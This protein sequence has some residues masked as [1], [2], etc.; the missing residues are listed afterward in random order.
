MGAERDHLVKFIFPKLHG[1]CWTHSGACEEVDQWEVTV[2]PIYPS[3]I[4]PSRSRLVGWVGEG[5]GGALDIQGVPDQRVFL[6][7]ESTNGDEKEE[8]F[9]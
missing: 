3:G 6:P 9:R 7:D 5:Y 8:V 1:L 4:Q 2:L